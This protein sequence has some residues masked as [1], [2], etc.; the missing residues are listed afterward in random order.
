[1]LECSLLLQQ[2]CPHYYLRGKRYKTLAY[3]YSIYGNSRTRNLM[4]HPRVSLELKSLQMPRFSR[5]CQWF[6]LNICFACSIPESLGVHK[7]SEFEWP[8]RNLLESIFRLSITSILL[9]FI[10]IYHSHPIVRAMNRT[11]LM[12]FHIMPW[13]AP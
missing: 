4:F 10:R 9:S 2:W 6:L 5:K 8:L 3:I 7:F 12:T 13:M 1:M 11:L